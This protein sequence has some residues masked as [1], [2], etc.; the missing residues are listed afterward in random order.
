LRDAAK[1]GY[2]DGIRVL[3]TIEIIERSN[4]PPAL[5]AIN[6]AN[7]GPAAFMLRNS[8]FYH[9]H[10]LTVRAFDPV[11]NA[12]DMH[13][14][15]AINFLRQPKRIA[16]EQCL[17]RREDLREAVRLFDAADADQRLA[18]LKHMRNKELAHWARFGDT[19][20]RPRIDDLFEFA[21]ATCLIW[22]RLSFG[23]GTML[24]EIDNQIDLYREAADAFW[25]KWER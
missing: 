14:R 20:D 7:A 15:A 5:E 1:D 19:V 13:L 17:E 25:S 21:R 24:I 22:E 8:A 16:D 10:M 9:L 4:R 2:S 11:C 23:A 6:K 18:T 3:A 12:D